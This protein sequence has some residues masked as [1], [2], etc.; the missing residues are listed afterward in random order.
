MNEADRD[1]REARRRAILDSAV[2]AFAQHGFFGSRIRDIAAGAGVAEGTIYLYFGGKDDLLVT[3]FRERVNEFCA[4]VHSI[5]AEES[6]FP[7]RL[8]RFIE[9]QFE[10]IEED[11]ALAT[12]LLVESRQSSSFYGGAVRDVLRSYAA[13]IDELLESGRAEGAFREDADLPLARRMLIGALEEI[14]LEWLLGDRSRPLGPTAP[15][16]A[17]LFYRGLAPITEVAPSGQGD[18]ATIR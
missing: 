12:V 9:L 11:P 13:A 2:R 6:S 3:A 17:A 16:M 8:T 18:G 14:E 4:A 7:E 5:L 1:P 10:G 15:T